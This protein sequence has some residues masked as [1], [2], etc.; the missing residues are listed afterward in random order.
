MEA[1][2][3][4]DSAAEKSEIPWANFD[5]SMMIRLTLVRLLVLPTQGGQTAEELKLEHS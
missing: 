3:F 2:W 5:R 4:G 1:V